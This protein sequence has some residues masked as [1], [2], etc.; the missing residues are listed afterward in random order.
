MKDS[1]LHLSTFLK[2]PK[3]VGAVAPSSKFLTKEVISSIEFKSLNTIVELGPGT[4][5]FTRAILE[6]AEPDT[7]VLCFE[8][9]K[10]F[11]RYLSN[12]I[13]DRRLTV[14]NSGAERLGIVLQKFKIKNVGCI[15]SG[16]PFFN[17]SDKKKRKIL[18][19]ARDSLNKQGRFILFQYTNGLSDML[20]SCFAKV[21]RKFVPVNVPP[22]FVYICE[23]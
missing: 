4:G 3:E 23:K 15:V 14:V 11:C 8:V 12:N 16:L 7:R 13:K 18:N 5:T 2:N 20:K 6:K 22:S 10:K 21:N 19:E 17:F 1:L 9:N